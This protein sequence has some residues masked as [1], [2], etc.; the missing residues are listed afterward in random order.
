MLVLSIGASYK[1]ESAVCFVTSTSE[2]RDSV[3]V[4]PLSL[5]YENGF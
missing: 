1:L 4:T 5:R 3:T 2:S